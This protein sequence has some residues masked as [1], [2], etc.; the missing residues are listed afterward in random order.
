MIISFYENSRQIV[1]NTRRFE[2][3]RIIDRTPRIAF[4]VD[5]VEISIRLESFLSSHLR[6]E[7]K[8]IAFV[9]KTGKW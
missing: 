7:S 9:A 5:K 6:K 4:H 8:G 2:W 3:L 1:S